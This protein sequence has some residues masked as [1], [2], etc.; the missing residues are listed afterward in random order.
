MKTTA[1]PL[2]KHSNDLKNKNTLEKRCVVKQRCI[3]TTGLE[4]YSS[5]C[6]HI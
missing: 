4:F 5:Y 1:M 6:F 3:Q 2:P